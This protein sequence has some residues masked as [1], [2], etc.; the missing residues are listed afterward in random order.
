MKILELVAGIIC[1][2]LGLHWV[3]QGTLLFPWPSNPAMDGHS[4]FIVYG[5]IAA[6]IGAG[7]VWHAK[8]QTSG[9]S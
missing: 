5:V 2:V 3:G 8:R 4:E 7:L 6:C 1:I 9:R